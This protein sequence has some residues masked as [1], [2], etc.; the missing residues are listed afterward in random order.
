M[1]ISQ[2]K[3]IAAWY[4][5]DERATT[6]DKSAGISDIAEEELDHS[7]YYFWILY[8]CPLTKGKDSY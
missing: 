2:V 8:T 3:S 7:K 4:A 1:T 5:Q 6:D